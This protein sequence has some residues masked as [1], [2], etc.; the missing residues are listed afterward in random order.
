MA[1]F[2]SIV[3]LFVSISA[4][5]ALDLSS[6]LRYPA[7]VRDTISESPDALWDLVKGTSKQLACKWC[8]V[9]AKITDDKDDQLI[10]E[11]VEF[12]CLKS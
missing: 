5:E 6:I 10:S 11:L 7:L 12:H 4:S 8:H 3:L 2:V 9:A 1:C